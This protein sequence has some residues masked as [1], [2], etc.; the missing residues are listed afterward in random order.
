MLRRKLQKRKRD[1]D[2]ERLKQII[3]DTDISPPI[4][5]LAVIGVGRM[6]PE[7]VSQALAVFPAIKAAAEGGDRGEVEQILRAQGMD[8]LMII[9]AMSYYDQIVGI[10]GGKSD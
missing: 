9:D 7:Q 10:K 5:A 6:T 3:R 2:R 1:P 8:E 4:K